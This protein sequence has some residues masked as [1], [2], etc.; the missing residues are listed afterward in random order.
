[1]EQILFEIYFAYFYIFF[2][3]IIV[4]ILLFVLEMIKFIYIVLKYC[5]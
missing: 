2:R 3:T 1:M 5:T 4:R